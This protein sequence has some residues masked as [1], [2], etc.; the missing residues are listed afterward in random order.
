MEPSDPPNSKKF[1]STIDSLASSL[2]GFD[3][4]PDDDRKIVIRRPATG[5]FLSVSSVY[6]YRREGGK[7]EYDDVGEPIP[8]GSIVIEA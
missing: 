6:I 7:I 4:R 3:L 5:D 8:D 1:A 2:R